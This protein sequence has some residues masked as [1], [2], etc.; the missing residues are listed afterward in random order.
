MSRVVGV[1]HIRPRALSMME[2]QIDNRFAHSQMGLGFPH[3]TKSVD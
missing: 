2:R 3:I 1:A